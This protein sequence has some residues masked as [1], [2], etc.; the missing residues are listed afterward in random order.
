MYGAGSDLDL[1]ETIMEGWL[2]ATTTPEESSMESL[3]SASPPVDDSRSML[4][5]KTQDW[6]VSGARSAP[7]TAKDVLDVGS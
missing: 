6:L 4:L 5:C 1:S 7:S 2:A 3:A